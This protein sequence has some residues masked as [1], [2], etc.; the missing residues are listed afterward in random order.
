MCRELFKMKKKI[1][2]MLL[3][4]SWN[5][6]LSMTSTAVGVNNSEVV[7]LE[8]WKF[9][10]GKS[11]NDMLIYNPTNTD[12]SVVFKKRT[13]NNSFLRKDTL[14]SVQ[15]IKPNDYVLVHKISDKFGK[16]DER[17]SE[18][19]VN[20]KY[21]GLYIVENKKT[22]P[23]NKIK[24]GIIINQTSNLGQ[25]HQFE[26]IYERLNFKGDQPQ[27]IDIVFGESEFQT[28]SFSK[29][30]V[31]N[32]W[33]I[34]FTNIK[35]EKLN[36]IQEENYDLFLTSTGEKGSLKLTLNNS[37]TKKKLI[38]RIFHCRY[39]GEIAMGFLIF[40]FNDIDFGSK[41][42]YHELE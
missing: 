13:H 4:I 10:N 7:I 22:V 36:I 21:A 26:I 29:G 34:N 5:P 14:F 16:L 27:S 28:L 6:L 39:A 25:Y 24:D 1:L 11:T 40:K 37:N 35:T 41:S 23:I 17:Y 38:D 32:P 19:F 33:N 8:Y 15:R 3:L 12:I 31:Y 2:L 42:K 18:V 30:A 9:E 20:D